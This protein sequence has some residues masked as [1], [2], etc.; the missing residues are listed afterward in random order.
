M[1]TVPAQ[2]WDGT[3]FSIERK[4]GKAPGTVIFSLSGPFT[5]RDM[6]GKLTP[7]DLQNMLDLQS[8]PGEEAISVN[9]L[10]LSDVPYMD[11]CG[12]GMIVTHYARCRNRGL[13][14]VA[15][16]ASARV[17]ELMRLT[18]VDTIIPLAA[19]VEAAQD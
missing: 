2:K 1:S 5:A 6:Y 11:S 3:P 16:G 14:M 8:G 13:K 19:T 12:L 10:D 7:L 9:V 18:K 17:L 15:A 4:Q